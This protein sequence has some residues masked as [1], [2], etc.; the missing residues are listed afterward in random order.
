MFL[1]LHNISEFV[2]LKAYAKFIITKI[3][4]FLN[5]SLKN[6]ILFINRS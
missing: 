5:L 6:K 1:L 4:S 2:L 3:K